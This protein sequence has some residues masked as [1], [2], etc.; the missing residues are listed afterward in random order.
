MLQAGIGGVSGAGSAGQPIGRPALTSGGPGIG[1]DEVPAGAFALGD[2]D[3]LVL[4]HRVI[5]HAGV[6]Q[7]AGGIG[8]G[9][10]ARLA[11]RLDHGFF[12]VGIRRGAALV[13][14]HFDETHDSPLP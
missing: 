11:A 10:L 1:P 7:G 4:V 8:P 2:L 9:D 13:F 6:G 14:F 3:Q 12:H 5:D